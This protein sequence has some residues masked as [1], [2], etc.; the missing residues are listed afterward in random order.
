MARKL[1]NLISVWLQKLGA[2]SNDPQVRKEW[3]SAVQKGERALELQILQKNQSE[4]D[5]NQ[6]QAAAALLGSIP[7]NSEGV[8]RIGSVLVVK[9]LS[10]SG[11]SQIFARTLTQGELITLEKNPALASDPRL[12]WE[13]LALDAD[14]EGQ[15]AGEFSTGK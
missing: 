10:A 15:E 1:K 2:L 14:G 6:A 11:L 4:I 12:A 8:L 5:R 3:R 9:R 13:R 7:D